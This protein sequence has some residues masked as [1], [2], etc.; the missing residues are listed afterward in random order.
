MIPVMWK[1]Q[2]L[3]SQEKKYFALNTLF[4]TDT[5]QKI[6]QTYEILITIMFRSSATEILE[7]CPKTLCW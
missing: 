4:V 1:E 5:V 3:I 2:F 6:I 7:A